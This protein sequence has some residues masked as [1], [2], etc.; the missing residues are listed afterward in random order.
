MLFHIILCLAL[1]LNVS[2]M[3]ENSNTEENN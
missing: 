1:G 3:G 2:A